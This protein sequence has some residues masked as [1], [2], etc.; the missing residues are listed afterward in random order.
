MM[1][2]ATIKKCHI[3]FSQRLTPCKATNYIAIQCV[4]IWIFFVQITMFCSKLQLWAPV[5]NM[6]NE[7]TGWKN[8]TA[9]ASTT[10]VTFYEMKTLEMTVM[11]AEWRNSYPTPAFS[12]LGMHMLD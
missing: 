11:V 2:A 7:R 3:S 12:F 9:S 6:Q 8:T 1:N 10:G 4:R 5:S